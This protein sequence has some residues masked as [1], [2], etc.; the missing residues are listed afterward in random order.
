MAESEP[1]LEELMAELDAGLDL[2]DNTSE[3]KPNESEYAKGMTAD[4]T[5]DD[6][7]DTD[8]FEAELE[9]MTETPV[10]APSPEPAP[11]PAPAP[12]LASTAPA[13]PVAALTAVEP[14]KPA[15]QPK[16]IP[17]PKEEAG[18]PMPRKDEQR[19]AEIEGAASS[20]SSWWSSVKASAEGLIASDGIAVDTSA[21][22]ADYQR[23]KEAR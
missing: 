7:M 19:T 11:A 20:V 4:N 13:Q 18:R 3:T 2:N 17:P 1:T 10:P 5:S 16:K 14:E 6:E 23:G 12:A 8:N 15:A 22:N 21:L 9:R